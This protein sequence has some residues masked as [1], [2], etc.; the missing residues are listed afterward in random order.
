MIFLMT[1][2]NEKFEV[3]KPV[4]ERSVLIK[5]MLEGVLSL[6]FSVV[7][8]SARHYVSLLRTCADVPRSPF[9]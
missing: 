9:T 5:N 2:D 4:A 6:F 3:E 7:I 1:S 8:A